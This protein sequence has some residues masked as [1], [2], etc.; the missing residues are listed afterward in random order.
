M[1]NVAKK[2]LWPL[3]LALI[4]QFS[5]AFLAPALLFAILIGDPFG[6]Y[7]RLECKI[8]KHLPPSQAFD[9]MKR[10]ALES[11]S[12][13]LSKLGLAEADFIYTP[14]KDG[15][16]DACNNPRRHH[17]VVPGIDFPTGRY[18]VEFFRFY[19]GNCPDCWDRVELTA[20]VDNCK[21]VMSFVAIR[22]EGWVAKPSSRGQARFQAKHCIKRN[23]S[24]GAHSRP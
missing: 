8:E 19:K 21:N 13:E 9:A 3:W 15:Y 2:Y 16:F 4:V 14:N 11:R 20:Q 24:N 7:S 10:Y 17:S 6:F 23:Q 5:V 22:R 12:E 1:N 18:R